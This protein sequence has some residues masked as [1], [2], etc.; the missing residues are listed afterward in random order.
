MTQ[1]Q[2]IDRLRASR[3][4]PVATS[5]LSAPALWGRAGKR[6]S[7]P[8][9]TPDPDDKHGT[10]PRHRPHPFHSPTHPAI[11]LPNHPFSHPPNPTFPRHGQANGCHIPTHPQNPMPR[12]GAEAETPPNQ[13]RPNPTE[14]LVVL[15]GQATPETRCSCF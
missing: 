11:R 14:V 2:L 5:W 6:R 10:T 12:G 8:T 15:Q 4:G 3:P 13:T 9:A 7:S 1:K